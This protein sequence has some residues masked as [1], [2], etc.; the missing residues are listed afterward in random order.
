M[1]IFLNEKPCAK[2]GGDKMPFDIHCDACHEFPVEVKTGK[3]LKMIEVL[4][5]LG[6]KYEEFLERGD[7]SAWSKDRFLLII[8]ASR[9]DEKVIKQILDEES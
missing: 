9:E 8:E 3:K 5:T 1:R 2:C 6:Y 4:C 7:G